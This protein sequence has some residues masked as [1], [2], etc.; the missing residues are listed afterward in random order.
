MCDACSARVKMGAGWYHRMGEIYD[1]CADCHMQVPDAERE[2]QFAKIDQIEDLGVDKDTYA[3]ELEKQHIRDHATKTFKRVAFA[4]RVLKDAELRSIYDNLGWQGL[5]KADMYAEES[6]FSS[7]A[8]AQYDKFFA[9]EDEEDR[10]YLLLHGRRPRFEPMGTLPCAAV[11]VC[12]AA[13]SIPPKQNL[14]SHAN[15]TKTNY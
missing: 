14:Y 6:V 1:L 11:P 12:L 4:Y 15:L 3:A 7:N 13:L 2:K 8:F 9:G 5:V 10:Q